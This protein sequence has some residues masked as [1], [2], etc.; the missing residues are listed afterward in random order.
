MKRIKTGKALGGSLLV[1]GAAAMLALLL[2]PA[3]DGM[4]VASPASAAPDAPA[5]GTITRQIASGAGYHQQGRVTLLGGTLTAP[6]AA[7]PQAVASAYLATRPAVLAGVDP[8]GLSLAKVTTLHR[9]HMVRY[10]QEHRGLPVIGGSA[11]VR[12][13]E[14]GRVRWVSSNAPAIADSFSITPTLSARQALSAVGRA[15]TYDQ[16]YIDSL[17]LANTARLAIFMQPSMTAP[18]LAYWVELPH[19]PARLQTLRAFVDAETGYIYRIENKVVSSALPTC[20]PGTQRAYVYP[21]NPVASPDLICVSLSDMLEPGATSL[22]NQDIATG[23]CIDNNNCRPV[24]L[25]PGLPFDI[26][27]CDDAPTA[28]A[29]AAGDFT[30][31]VF[32]SDTELDDAFSE[33]QMFYHVNKAY[34]VARSLGGFTNLSARPLGAIVNFRAPIDLAGD[35]LFGDI[36]AQSCSGPTYTGD[37]PLHNFD[38]AFFV[39]AGGF[40]GYPER[41]SIVFGQGNAGDFAYDGDVIAHEFG[42]AVMHTVAPELAFGFLDQ[43]GF[44]PTPGGMHE[45]Y[46]DLMTMFVT[47]DPQVGEYVGQAFGLGAVRNIDNAHTCPDSLIGET[48][49]DSLPFT[50]AIWEARNAVATNPTDKRLFD[51]AVFAAQQTFDAGDQFATAAAKTVL[52]IEAALGVA[53][54]SAVESIFAARGLDGCNNRVVDGSKTKQLLIVGSNGNVQPTG[55]VPGPV[56]F[57]YDLP[58]GA[59][60]ITVDIAATRVFALAGL[61]EQPALR[62]GIKQGE[63]ILWDTSNGSLAGDYTDSVPVTI[64]EATTAG[65]MT[66]QGPFAPGSYHLQFFIEGGALILFNTVISHAGGGEPQPDAG[67]DPGTPTDGDGTA[68]CGCVVGPSLEQGAGGILL[69]LLTIL[70]IALVRRRRV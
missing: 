33:I 40:L 32:V 5:V 58:G 70:G 29:N 39:P 52:E 27:W 2:V 56:Q 51:Q 37:I 1:G 21:S 6:S 19:S 62:V 45:G 41:D 59:D 63:A 43:Y 28:A 24:E 9:G 16:A 23:N 35:D 31:H 61:G 66:M 18:R 64:D 42:H 10:Q 67:V 26:H 68:G 14:R 69:G 25:F 57:R 13:D 53:A 50:G 20:E 49:E 54:A 47:D 60:T 36:L 4:S 38:N 22:G 17:D 34:E 11:T 12:L 8:A 55:V 3:T 65:T 30:D 15:V 7:A 48:H 46:A 44:D